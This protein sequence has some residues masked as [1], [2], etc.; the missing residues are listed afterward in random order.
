M[1]AD[2]TSDT[3]ENNAGELHRMHLPWRSQEFTE[4]AHKLDLATID[5]LRKEKGSRYV[6][7][8]KLLELRR[9]PPINTSEDLPVPIGLPRN[10][11]N[12]VYLQTKSKIAQGVLNTHTE[13]LEFPSI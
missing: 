3:E 7:R 2:C 10:C 4:F 11:Y 1:D 9:L 5:C 13:P 12:L 6:Q 8:T